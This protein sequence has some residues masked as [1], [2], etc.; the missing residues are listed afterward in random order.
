MSEKEKKAIRKIAVI[1]YQEGKITFE[2]QMNVLD[3]LREKC[4]GIQGQEFVSAAM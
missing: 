2:E 4:D 3:I 1:L